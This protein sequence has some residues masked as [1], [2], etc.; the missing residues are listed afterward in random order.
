MA[1]QLEKLHPIFK[2]YTGSDGVR[3]VMAGFA[4]DASMAGRHAVQLVGLSIFAAMA[5]NII[6]AG[7]IKPGM[8]ILGYS[9]H[10]P[11]ARYAVHTLL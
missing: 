9:V 4:V 1:L 11:M 5:D 8:Q 10:G 2:L 7:F 3:T 6:A